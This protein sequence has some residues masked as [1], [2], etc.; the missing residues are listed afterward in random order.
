MSFNLPPPASPATSGLEFAD[1][2]YDISRIDPLA[3]FH[4]N[5][6]QVRR[7][8]EDNLSNFSHLNEI[9]VLRLGSDTLPHQP[10]TIDATAAPPVLSTAVPS[11]AHKSIT[12]LPEYILDAIEGRMH[13]QHAFAKRATPPTLGAIPPC[14]APAGVPGP[15]TAVVDPETLP[16]PTEDVA[17]LKSDLAKWGYAICAN[18]L[19]AEQVQIIRTAVE[20]QAEAERLVGVGHL[21]TAHK[22][23]GDQ[24]NQR[25]WNLPNKGD[26]FLDLLN[27]PLIDAVMPWFL[28]GNFSLFTMSAN[29]ARPGT[30]GIYM[31]R[32]QMVMS[33]DTTAHAYVLNAM[34][35]LTDVSEEK[36]A[37]RT[38]VNTTDEPRPVILQ[39]FCRFF[40]R[41]IEN[42]QA[43]LSDKVKAKLSE[44]QRALLGLPSM[45]PGG[46]GQG[47]ASYNWP[48]TQVGRMRAAV[49]KE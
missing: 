16:K 20:E 4:E 12:I 19:S 41:Q 42:Y 27:H 22:K 11:T 45:K 5:V 17:Q 9:I 38:G 7:W 47:F 43:I 1:K 39:S 26:E 14:F 49:G 32:D 13:S 28:G 21:D 10:L 31:H 30:S 46:K 2:P 37:T 8:I 25:V 15:C 3:R 36:G 18:A 35:Y 29:I 33:P 6:A 48:G 24:P 23:A 40:V 34:W 44:R